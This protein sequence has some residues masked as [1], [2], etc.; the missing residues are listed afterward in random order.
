MHNLHL[1]SEI[2]IDT[3][4]DFNVK[5]QPLTVNS[6]CI[7]LSAK[8]ELT[9][10]LYNSDLIMSV[11]S[12]TSPIKSN[13]LPIYSS[14]TNSTTE[15][16]HLHLAQ[17]RSKFLD[18]LNTCE[19]LLDCSDDTQCFYK[20]RSNVTDSASLDILMVHGADIMS[21]LSRLIEEA[22][23][24]INYTNDFLSELSK[25]LMQMEKHVLS[26]HTY[27]EEMHSLN[28]EFNDGLLSHTKEIKQIFG[29]NKGLEEVRRFILAKL[30]VIAESIGKKRHEDG[31]KL[32]A[33]EQRIDEL[34]N[35]L[36]TYSDEIVQVRE[37][38]NALEK[39][40]LLD[41]LMRISNRR[42]YEL[43]IR[44]SLRRYRRN[45]ESF[46][47][48]LIDVDDFKIVNDTYGHQAGDKCL[49]EI[50]KSIK[51]CLRK[52][53]FLA[54]HGGDE[55]IAILPGA[56]VADV[57]KV[58]E[59]IRGWIEK[60]VFW[61]NQ[62]HFSVTISAGV[63]VVTASDKDPAS[64]FSRVDSAMYE[65]KRCGRNRIRGL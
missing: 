59:K 22:A 30:S 13:N 15:K 44:E 65:A 12:N 19:I 52:T 48:I 45:Q 37:R 55:M 53:D 20:I 62:V 9:R 56:A 57:R 21:L 33:A 25:D 28:N 5:K 26:C 38:A 36:R 47:L 3:L 35:S 61:H 39:E 17:T 54:R 29:T 1:L 24:K 43:Q 2:F 4:R 58:A 32:Q 50:A 27:N 16:C 31:L 14:S 46:G 10:I 49:R 6:L 40:V 63:T 7:A 23:R 42:A 60:T 51:F 34:Q 41:Q 8:Q 64:L 11:D 18:I